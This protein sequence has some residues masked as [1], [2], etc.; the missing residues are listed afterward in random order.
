VTTIEPGCY[1]TVRDAGRTGFLAGP[2]PTRGAAE[3]K[4]GE[5]RERAVGA[6][7]WAHFYA[8]GTARV[9]GPLR[10]RRGGVTFGVL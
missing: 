10:L 3:A 1:V 4:V 9:K 7:P 5:A 2:Y 6:D 8:F